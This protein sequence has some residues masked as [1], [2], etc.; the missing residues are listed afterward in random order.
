MLLERI[1]I[2]KTLEIE[3]DREGYRYHLVSKVEKTGII[4]VCVTAIKSNGITF[5]FRPKDEI[6]L[7]YRDENQMWEWTKVKA[8]TMKLDGDMVHYFD[9]VNKGQSFNR[10]NAYRVILD[11]D[12]EIGYFNIPENPIKAAKIPM[13]KEVQEILCDEDG[14]E[15]DKKQVTPDMVGKLHVEKKER[16]VPMTGVTKEYIPVNIKDVSENGIGIFTNTKLNIDDGF[17]V[18]IP[19]SYGALL[20]RAKVVRSVEL[21]GNRQYRYYYGC[22]YTES[23]KRLILFIYDIQRKLIKKQKER[24]EF[25][26]SV[27]A[28]KGK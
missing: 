1:P 25:E 8:G 17:F 3:V 18:G 6:R 16:M 28:K 26:D 21:K 7:V 23:D 12:V 2:G 24:R 15:I 10:R 9:I 4:R 20:A 19:S 22:T 5:N 11:E 27:R 14:N 13:V